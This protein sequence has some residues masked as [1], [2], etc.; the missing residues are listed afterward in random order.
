[1]WTFGPRL[2]VEGEV[3][4]NQAGQTWAWKI[5]DNGTVAAKGT[6]TTGGRSGSFEVER[7]VGDLAGTDTVSFRAR[8]AGQT[9]KGT[10]AF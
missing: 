5:K 9:C 1:M 6:A 2:E 10:I 3:D 8:H 7:Q 4:S